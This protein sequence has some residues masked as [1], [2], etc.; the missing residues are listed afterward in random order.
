MG[1]WGGEGAIDMKGGFPEML[2]ST[3]LKEFI[4]TEVFKDLF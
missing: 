4:A 1:G 2:S 3:W